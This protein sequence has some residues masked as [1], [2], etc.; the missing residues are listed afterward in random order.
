M[1]RMRVPVIGL[2]LIMGCAAMLR[3]EAEEKSDTALDGAFRLVRE[4]VTWGDV[5]GAAALVARDGKIVREEAYGLC[6]VENKL[7]FTPGTLCWIASITKPVTVAAAM[8]LV[9]TGKLALDDSIE[10]YLPEFKEQKVREA[11]H[12]SVTIRQLMSHTSGIQAN[13]PSR[14]SLF[15]EQAWLGRTIAEIPPLIAQTPLEF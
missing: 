13:P 2:A 9:E 5:P 12:H 15:F 3:A 6:D 1:T 14:P 7:A 10:K 11:Q 8:K 4:A